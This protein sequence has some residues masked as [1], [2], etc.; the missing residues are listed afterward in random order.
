MEKTLGQILIEKLTPDELEQ[1]TDSFEDGSLDDV[2]YDEL[3]PED[4]KNNPEKYADESDDTQKGICKPIGKFYKEGSIKES[5][6]EHDERFQKAQAQNNI[7][8]LAE[9]QVLHLIDIAEKG[10]PDC[11]N[12]FDEFLSDFWPDFSWTPKKSVPEITAVL[13][14]SRF[15]KIVP[16]LKETWGVNME[17]ELRDGLKEI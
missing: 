15:K 8:V 2:F 16:V 5:R 14:D 3:F 6:R 10:L 17:K 4:K 7:P 12:S 9:N 11:Y 13:A 1:L